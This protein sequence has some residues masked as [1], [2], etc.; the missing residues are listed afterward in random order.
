V[1]DVFALE[2]LRQRLQPP[3]KCGRCGSLKLETDW[4]PDL[5]RNGDYLLRCEA[6]GAEARKVRVRKPSVREKAKK[7]RSSAKKKAKAR[8]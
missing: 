3:E 5:G 1:V 7:R 8:R 4:R 6:C 2:T